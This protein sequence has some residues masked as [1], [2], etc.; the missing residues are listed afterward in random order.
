MRKLFQKILIFNSILFSILIFNHFA[1]ACSCYPLETVD[2]AFAKTTNV[3]VLKL[4][5]I[6]Q[7]DGEKINY[8]F[9]VKKIFKGELKADEM[10]NFTVDSN[11]SWLF[12]ADE[13]GTEFLFYLQ[14][15]PAEN[16]K[17][18]GSVCSR[19]GRVKSKTNDLSYLENVNKLSD[20]TRLSGQLNKFI[21]TPG[22][23]E[24]ISLIPLAKLKLKVVGNGKN[25]DLIT[26]ENGVYE[27][28]DLPAG[29]YKITPEKID[30][31]VFSTEKTNFVEVE[32]KAKSHTEQDFIYAINN[33]ISGKIVEPN[34]SPIK[35]ICLDLISKNIGKTL[36]FRHQTCSDDKGKFEF[37]SI[38]V[39][40]YL[41]VI[42][43]NEK[44]EF[45]PVLNNFFSPIKTFYYSNAKKKEAATEI[46]VGA[47][48][49]LKNLIL[50]P[51]EMPE[52]ITLNGRLIYSDGQPA[53]DEIIQFFKEDDISKTFE[54][55]VISDFEAKTDENGRFT[56]KVLK[57]EKGFL[58]GIVYWLVGQYKNC[59]ETENFI[60][61]EGKSIQQL[62][63]S[64]SDIN[65]TEDLNNIELKFP[66]PRCEEADKK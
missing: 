64:N 42:N 22:Q 62:K 30:G 14:K 24:S 17:W 10:L 3:V 27:I 55:L 41:I 40:T 21:E 29:K 4:E 60:K 47:N 59:A 57:G 35:E 65:G 36:G 52:M 44:N 12:N 25:I 28:Y 9:S 13:I 31:F 16:E 26:D 20:K 48:Y 5:S 66:F 61:K 43:N 7:N 34:G 38:P 2:K 53:A 33:E 19:S 37:T 8:Y 23:L 46:S 1:N 63:T 18:I 32:I 58:R 45:D 39:G 49:F 56:I 51:P 11:C 6:K 54:E 15:R 50:I